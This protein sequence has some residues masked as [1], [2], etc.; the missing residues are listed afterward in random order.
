MT[1]TFTWRPTYGAQVNSKPKVARAQYGDGYSQRAPMGINSN[2]EIWNLTFS[3]REDVE[4]AA[5][6]A[7]LDTAAGSDSF[8]WTNLTGTTNLY[9][10]QTYSRT[11]DDEDKNQVTAQFEQV[12]GG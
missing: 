9:I 11:F 5:I 6:K 3:G 8:Y 2:P 1:A 10:C 12:F 4:A 7:F